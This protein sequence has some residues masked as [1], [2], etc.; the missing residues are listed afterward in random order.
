MSKAYLVGQITITNPQAYATYAAQVP[1]TIAAYG[2]QYLVRGGHATQLEGQAQGER[3]VVVEFANR[4]IAE[5][6]YHSEAYQA[7]IAHRINNSIGTIAIVEGFG[8]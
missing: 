8:A 1:Q 6:W 5:A 4:E 7:I 3:H 2:G